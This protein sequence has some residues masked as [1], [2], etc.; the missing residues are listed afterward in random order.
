[1]RL[2]GERFLA[3]GRDDDQEILLSDFAVKQLPRG[4]GSF[5]QLLQVSLAVLQAT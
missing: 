5:L 2:R 4:A 3:V 1:M